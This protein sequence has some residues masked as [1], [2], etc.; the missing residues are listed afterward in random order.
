MP[1]VSVMLKPASSLCNMRCEYCFYHSLA[2]QRSAPSH[3]MM[4]GDTL[5]NVIEKAFAYA[6]GAPVS[7]SFQGGE[8]L[9]AGKDFF[10]LAEELLRTLNRKRSR[11]SV[12]VQTNGTLLDDEWC[13]M[14]TRFGWLVGLSLDGDRNNNAMRVF[15]DGTPSFD[16]VYAAAKLLEKHRTPFNI[17]AV[18]T[19]PVAENI[20]RVYAFFRRNKFRHLQF[21]PVLRPLR[22]A[23]EDAATEEADEDIYLT[24][25][26][27]LNFLKKAFSLYMKD[28]ID[29]RYTSIRQ[30][31][32]FVLLAGFKRAE[33]C[34]MNGECTR[35]FVVE[36]DGA[37]YPCD[38]YC[39]DEYLAGNINE[40]SFEEL[41]E[42][43]VAVK[44]LE[45]GSV[46]PEKCDGCKY[47][48]MCNGGCKRERIDIDKCEAYTEFFDYALPH[49]K[50]MS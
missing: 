3:G 9:L 7:L 23:G 22:R 8:P 45:E 6:D 39:L 34:G 16:A 29:G 32:N 40:S 19:R 47:L 48:R 33:Q 18:L 14:F 41:A 10:R 44:F 24:P 38:F 13:E 12:G 5:K 17:L 50:R 37:V 43:P 30:F 15:E 28:M 2:G 36:G 31:D 25:A 26:A 4:S 11:V 35:Q 46:L 42:S 27:Y 1:S 49:L 20:E 21:I